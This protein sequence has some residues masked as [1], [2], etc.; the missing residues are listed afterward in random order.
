MTLKSALS[1][2]PHLR[3]VN[4]NDISTRLFA[5]SKGTCFI[6]YNVLTDSYELHSLLSLDET[7]NSCNAVIEDS[8]LNWRIIE[9]FLANNHKRF[10]QEVQDKRQEMQ[11]LY[12]R[13]EE[14]RQFRR[15][16][17]QLEIIK[18]TLGRRT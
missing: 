12:E 18:R 7:N 5:R 11:H 6:A 16:G 2:Q 15:T 1:R 3:L 10:G 13:N 14:A 9:D 17:D 8:W 4:I